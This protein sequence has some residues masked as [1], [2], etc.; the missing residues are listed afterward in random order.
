MTKTIDGKKELPATTSTLIFQKVGCDSCY[1]AAVPD[2]TGN[3]KVLVGDGKYKITV[4]NAS[5]P[6]AELL[7]VGQER[8]VDTGSENSPT[9]E[10]RFDVKIRT[11]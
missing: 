8:F 3:Y 10:I 9:S 6:E 1:V 2:A 5:S 7:A 11:D 4:R